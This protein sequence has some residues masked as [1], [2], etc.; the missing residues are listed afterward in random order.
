MGHGGVGG[1]K[2][3]LFGRPHGRV[4]VFWPVFRNSEGS[5]QDFDPFWVI[6]SSFQPRTP[7]IPW[8]HGRDWIQHPKK[9]GIPCCRPLGPTFVDPKVSRAGPGEG[10]RVCRRT[11]TL[12]LL[13]WTALHCSPQDARA[14]AGTDTNLATHTNTLRRTWCKMTSSPFCP[15]VLQGW[16]QDL[17]G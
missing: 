14:A 3:K 17:L 12:T 7:I 8:N 4:R 5:G 1:H 15:P 10:A 11:V 9:W 16:S 6:S 2:K 13:L